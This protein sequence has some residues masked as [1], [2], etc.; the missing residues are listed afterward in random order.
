M[1]LTVFSEPLAIERN[2]PKA[3]IVKES[4]SQRTVRKTDDH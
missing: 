1:Q 2:L 4:K 3:C